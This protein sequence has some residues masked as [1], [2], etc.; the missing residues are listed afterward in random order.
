MG[1][2]WEYSLASTNWPLLTVV[3]VV[4][5][6]MVAARQHGELVLRRARQPMFYFVMGFLMMNFGL[7][8]GSCSIRIV[9]L[10]AY[11]N[12]FGL[13]GWVSIVIG[14]VLGSVAMRWQARRYAERMAQ[15]A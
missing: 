1:T 11:G 9:I 2:R 15:A 7:V 3:G 5:G 12:V 8:L 14:V 10:S 4:A 6:A 13:V